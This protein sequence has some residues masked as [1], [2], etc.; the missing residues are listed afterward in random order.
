M[1]N[2]TIESSRPLPAAAIV[3]GGVA[4]FLFVLS[5]A[6]GSPHW[7]VGALLPLAI[8]AAVGFAPE[9]GFRAQ[10]SEHGI[11]FLDQSEPIR[12]ESMEGLVGKRPGDPAKPG[13]PNYPIQ[14]IHDQGVL[15]I[16]AHLNMASDEVY[17]FLLGQFP[18]GGSRVVH[19]ALAEY[20][21]NQE[22]TF[23]ADRVWTYCARRHLGY[24]FEARKTWAGSLAAFLTGV[25]WVILG[26]AAKTK[27][28]P[29]IAAGSITAIVAGFTF[30]IIWVQSRSPLV[31]MKN[32]R[33]SSLVISPV[34]LAMVQGTE[35]GKMR[36]DELRNVKLNAARGFFDSDNRSTH[37]PGL[38]LEIAG[39]DFAILDV[40]DRPLAI[41][42]QRINQYWKQ[43]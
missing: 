24:R 6:T 41:I 20:L 25:A 37:R 32:W 33:D 14:V 42:M 1:N 3:F 21:R 38:I 10:F 30:C 31:R 9:P 13:S 43:S 18:Q 35:K 27:F 29:W 2:P 8:A 7:A 12:Y 11:E 23:G 16:P 39:A 22:A 15:M 4:A 5:V 28:T 34:G 17:R 40:Y 36:W 19:G 26:I